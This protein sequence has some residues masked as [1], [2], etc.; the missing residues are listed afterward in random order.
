MNSYISNLG[1]LLLFSG[2]LLISCGKDNEDEDSNNVVQ[3]TA[4]VGSWF[5]G[6]VVAYILQSGDPGYQSGQTHGFIVAPQE[7]GSLP[8]G[9]S[10]TFIGGTS[11]NLGQGKVNTDY[12][13]AGCPDSGGAA[14]RCYDLELNGFSDWHL[15]SLDELKKLNLNHEIIDS[16]LLANGGE[17]FEMWDTGSIY[18]SSTEL[19]NNNGLR[20][21]CLRFDISNADYQLKTSLFRVRPISSF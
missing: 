20:A 4:E 12:I 7:L 10:G 9:C 14:R 16:V 15:P 1:L 13:V 21:Y 19:F 2:F 8:W 17:P 5:G 3:V 18:W 6:G 11:Q